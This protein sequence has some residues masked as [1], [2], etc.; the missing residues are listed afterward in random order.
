MHPSEVCQGRLDKGGEGEV[1]QGNEGGRGGKAKGV[2]R[3]EPDKH[4]R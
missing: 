4:K 3:D 2:S 1:G